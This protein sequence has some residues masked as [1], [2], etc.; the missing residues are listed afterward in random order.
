VKFFYVSIGYFLILVLAIFI[1]SLAKPTNSSENIDLA[2]SN[3]T[4]ISPDT[5][6]HLKK[7]TLL[8]SKGKIKNV[9][10]E[11]DDNSASKVIDGS[12]KFLIPGLIDSHV[13]LYHAT[14]LKKKY[15]DNYE[16]LYNQYLD[17]MPKSYLYFG[18]T[19]IVEPNSDYRFNNLLQSAPISPNLLHCGRGII[20]SDGFMAEEIPS[21]Q[22][23]KNAPNFLHDRF[24]DGFMPIGVDPEK[25]TPKAVIE[26]LLLDG[27]SCAKIYYDE[28]LWLPEA[29]RTFKLPS[30]RIIRE[31]VSEANS[32]NLPVIIHTTS[33]NGY[34]FAADTNVD[35]IAHGPWDWDGNDYS[36]PNIPEEV[37]S[38]VEEIARVEI[39]IQPTVGALRHTASMFNH[40][41]LRNPELENVLAPEYLNYLHNE[42]QQQRKLFIKQFG[43]MIMEQPSERA[44][45]IVMPKMLDR[46]RRIVNIMYKSKTNL[47]FG[48]DTSSGGYGW[49]NP[50]GLNGFLEIKDWFNS[51]VP[52]KEILVSMTSGN[53]K[54][55]K[56]YDKIGSIEPGKNAD[57]LLLSENPLVN[58]EAYNSIEKIILGGV[59]IERDTLSAK[60]REIAK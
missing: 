23:L 32:K 12:G 33:P 31:L 59:S 36:D 58:I 42:A 15:T 3:V 41:L 37:Y 18:F 49:G 19:T 1:T 21:G 57:L 44:I 38:A 29:M 48:T 7:A 28:A 51:G 26:Q 40:Q 56:I 22:L 35:I 45:E 60:V 39:S 4:V 9:V 13:H 20:L 43:P 17:Q 8:V 24:K 52:L 27:A 46:Y 25:H 16:V 30:R 53:A 11:F 47:L 54:A 6:F 34:K 50:P 10:K 2:I 14:G 5:D 55:L